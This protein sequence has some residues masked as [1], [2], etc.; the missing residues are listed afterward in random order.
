MFLSL[1]GAC[2]VLAGRL[3]GFW[4]L[5]TVLTA[6]TGL[7]LTISTAMAWQKDTSYTGLV[8]RALILVYC[9]W[10]VLLALYLLRRTQG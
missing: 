1:C 6:A 10:I 4:Q 2:L 8:Q 9:I 5:Y 3:P 7:A